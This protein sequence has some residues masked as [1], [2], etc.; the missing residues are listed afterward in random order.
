MSADE[1]ALVPVDDVI[2][3]AP[4]EDAPEDDDARSP[5]DIIRAWAEKRSKVLL[6]ALVIA[7]LPYLILCNGM[8]IL[9]VKGLLSSG[10]G[11]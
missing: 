3:A 2:D 10:C 5:L 7:I 11:G 4:A 1:A 8:A 9:V 6:V